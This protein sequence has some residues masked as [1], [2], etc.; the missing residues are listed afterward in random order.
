MHESDF[1]INASWSFF[2][3]SHGKSPCDG[4]GGTVKRLT[5]LESLRRPLQ[6]QIGTVDAMLAYCSEKL[7]S[8][9]FIELTTNE[10]QQHRQEL[11]ERFKLASTIKGT[12]GFH[13]FEPI[14]QMKIGMKRV[15]SDPTF[16]LLHNFNVSK[17]LY[18][19]KWYIGVILEVDVENGD[20]QVNFMHPNGPSRSFQWPKNQD[21]CWVPNQ[22][23]LCTID[24]PSLATTR[25]QYHLSGCSLQK[26]NT[27]LSL[28]D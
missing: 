12:R 26:I 21:I 1:G 10:L 24:C 3:A 23:I 4:I 6:N 22:H 11:E 9:K 17:A 14:G 19:Q 8:I 16:S 28:F 20:V 7:S 18:D 2:S 15:S 25:G 27:Q 13:F 5:A